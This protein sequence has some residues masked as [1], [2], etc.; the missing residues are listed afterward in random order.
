MDWNEDISKYQKLFTGQLKQKSFWDGKRSFHRR[1][2]Q[3]LKMYTQY[4]NQHMSLRIINLYKLFGNYL[5]YEHQ[6][7]I[8]LFWVT[9]S[10]FEI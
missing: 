9:G 3:S 6:G 8:I 10:M 7:R 5:S 1:I 2:R 4:T